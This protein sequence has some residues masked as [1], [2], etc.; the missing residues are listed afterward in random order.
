[1]FLQR[2]TSED[3]MKRTQCS[4][5]RSND[6]RRGFIKAAGIGAGLFLAG[7]GTEVLARGAN[8]GDA[9]CTLVTYFEVSEGKLEEFKA[10]IPQ[11][12]KR[13]RSESGCV[14][15]AFSIGGQVVFCREGYDNAKAV[16]A[17]L[18]NVDALVKEALKIS[19][20][21]RLEVHGPA[22]ELDKLRAPLADFGPQWFALVPGGIRRG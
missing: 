3:N 18:A 5:V 1:M 14:H 22:T 4:S 19:K 20:I 12:V 15:Y 11:F 10:L 17:H 7:G 6:G 21:I 9:V 8:K 13:T 2:Q 16:L